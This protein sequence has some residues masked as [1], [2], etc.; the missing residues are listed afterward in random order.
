MKIKKISF[1]YEYKKL[2]DLKAG[3][4]VLGPDGEKF[5]ILEIHKNG[6]KDI[7]RI[8]L[9][10]GR[11][12]DTSETHLSTVH[13]RNSHVRPG[14]KVYDTVSTKYIKDHLE[15]YIFEIPTD[16]T[17]SW[18][19]LDYPQ[20]IEM[21][22]LHEYEPI[23]EE[24]IIPDTLKDPK[25]VYIKKVEKLE[26]QEEC[27]CLAL[28]YPWGLYVTEKGI[29]THNSLLTNLCMSYIITLFGLMREPHKML[30]HSAMTS[31]SQPYGTL[32]QLKDNTWKPIECLIVGDELKPI[33][34]EESKVTT[35]IE[36]GE[37]DTYELDFGNN[38]KIRCSLGHWWLL[39][40]FEMNK[41][42]KI[43]TKDFIENKDRYGVPELEDLKKDK[44][45]IIECHKQFEKDH[46]SLIQLGFEFVKS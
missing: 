29:I 2:G 24:F 13:F 42:V 9:D 11:Y 43:Q 10:D 12:F 31:Y 5:P 6:V 4:E 23:D 35:I 45:L 27:W 39:W 21:L 7:Y 38:K 30:G 14:K 46:M 18:K 34:D 1:E 25:K 15:K 44:N 28:G 32:I 33:L 41:Y 22:P 40:D 26:K 36:Q 19:E 3:D 37:Q 8:T 20:F 17:F 16:E